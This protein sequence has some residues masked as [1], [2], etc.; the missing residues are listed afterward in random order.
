MKV[1]FIF[2]LALICCLATVIM[3]LTGLVFFIKFLCDIFAN[4]IPFWEALLTNIVQGLGVFVLA[5]LLAVITGFLTE[6]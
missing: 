1:L 4:D 2:I 3:H 6:V 5:A